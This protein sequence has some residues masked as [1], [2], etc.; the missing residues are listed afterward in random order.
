MWVPDSALGWVA[1][2]VQAD[3]GGGA[4]VTVLV[5]PY[6]TPQAHPRDRVF[7]RNPDM[8]AGIPDLADLSYLNEPAVLSNL[9]TR[10]ETRNIYTYCGIVLVAINPY[11]RLPLCVSV[12]I[13]WAQG[14]VV[15]FAFVSCAALG[16][17]CLCL[18]GLGGGGLWPTCPF[19]ATRAR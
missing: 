8:F 9:A 7:L 5:E 13:A 17:G 15:P 2:T 18:F 10:F 14:V 3:E 12:A 16:S 6:A 11:E 19:A 4:A 1:A